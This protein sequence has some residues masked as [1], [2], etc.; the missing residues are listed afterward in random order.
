MKGLG[1]FIKPVRKRPA[2]LVILGVLTFLYCY[3]EYSFI[4]PIVFGVSILKTGNVLDSI[5]HLIQIVLGYIPSISPTSIV[6]ILLAIIAVSMIAGLVLSGSLNV[7]NGALTDAPKEKKLFAKGIQKHYLKVSRVTF[8]SILYTVLFFIFIVIVAIPS[9]VITNAA[10]AEKTELMSVAYILDLIT[11]GIL[12]F[13]ILFFKTYILFWYPAAI[14]YDKKLFER[15]KRAADSSFWSI[16]VRFVGFDLLLLVFQ[17]GLFYI[18]TIL[19]KNDSIVSEVFSVIILI[20]VNWIFK[21]VLLISVISFVFSKFI[22]YWN[23]TKA[24]EE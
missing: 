24:V 6:F 4:M 18:N 7:L 13:G 11:V 15:G 3:I 5:M 19:S 23:R 1:Y 8:L 10:V 21:T 17:M 12:F 2:L 9:I 20:F 16:V 14:N 22:T